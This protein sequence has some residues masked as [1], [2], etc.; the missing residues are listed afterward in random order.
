MTMASGWSLSFP[1]GARIVALP[2]TAILLMVAQFP[3]AAWSQARDTTKTGAAKADSGMAGMDHRNMPGMGGKRD[4][5]M[6]A[7]PGM[8]GMGNM[9]MQSAT[10][11]MAA[12]GAMIHATPPK[13]MMLRWKV[14]RLPGLLNPL[15]QKG[16]LEENLREGRRVYYQNC[17]QCH[18]PRLDG[19]GPFAKALTLPPR[20][21]DDP[22][23]LPMHPESYV[24]W[25]VAKGAYSLPSMMQPWNSA[26]PAF[27]DFLTDDE[28]WAV[29]LYLYEQSGFKPGP[30]MWTEEQMRRGG[31]HVHVMQ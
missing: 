8:A 15:R 17:V 6:A 9:V 18:G 26:M 27:E 28:I 4:S 31:A 7:M 21:L 25:R 5:A 23:F 2:A 30:W 24:F 1:R 12:G 16:S 10:A 29:V 22:A 11:E 13:D 19:Q 3:E 20:P 14:I